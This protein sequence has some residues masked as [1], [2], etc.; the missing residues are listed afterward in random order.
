MLDEPTSGLDAFAA[1]SVVENLKR[2]TRHRDLSCLMTIHQPSWALLQLIDRVELL[3][4]GKVYYSGTPADM[5]TYFDSIGHRV[6]VG[7]NPADHYITIAENPGQTDEGEKQVVHLIDSW[8]ARE[9]ARLSSESGNS[10]DKQHISTEE[11]V[12]AAKED[13][14]SLQVYKTWPTPW[15]KEL[16]VLTERNFIQ[17]VGAEKLRLT[18]YCHPLTSS[19]TAPRQ[20]YRHCHSRSN[21]RNPHHCWIRLLPTG[22]RATGRPGPRRCALL[23]DHQ[24][25]LYRHLP[26]PWSLCRTASSDEA[27]AVGGNVSVV[28]LLPEQVHGGSAQQCAEATALPVHHLL[29]VSGES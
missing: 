7:A 2:T 25:H 3:A 16:S 22:A 28:E 24:Y 1:Y 29:D 4:R 19:L 13:D 11:E 27:G 5:V 23:P 18:T 17:L 15:V 9:Q 14:E 8:A 12:K 6:P 10:S 20:E 21:D 26:R